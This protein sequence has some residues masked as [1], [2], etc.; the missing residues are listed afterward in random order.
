M[1]HVFSLFFIL[2]LFGT[3]LY[4]ADLLPQSI[5]EVKTPG[6]SEIQVAG[7]SYVKASSVFEY[8]YGL[9]RAG[10]IDGLR[11]NLML[12]LDSNVVGF[13]I[14]IYTE[15][16]NYGFVYNLTNPKG[17]EVI[18]PSPIGVPK[19]LLDRPDV[20]G[21]GQMLSQNAMMLEVYKENSV[22]PVPNSDKVQIE[23]GRWKFSIAVE[24][25][26]PEIKDS[27][28]VSVFVKK[29]KPIGAKTRGMIH[30]QTFA[31]IESKVPQNLQQ[32]KTFIEHPL[33]LENMGIGIQLHQ[34]TALNE[35]FDTMCDD[36][37]R[38]CY[39][40]LSDLRRTTVARTPGVLNIHFVKRNNFSNAGIAN[41]GGSV[42]SLFSNTKDMFDGVFVWTDPSLQ[43]ALENTKLTFVHELG[44]HL[45]LYHT[46]QDCISDTK[47][48]NH[49]IEGNQNPI[50]TNVMNAGITGSKGSF[51]AG[52]RDILLRSTVVELYEP[53]K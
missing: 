9:V 20:L 14:V 6:L 17:T 43:S 28:R 42:S 48:F 52:Q 7:K 39:Q 31:S 53:K 4:A 10:L 30:V 26:T 34:H 40:M 35:K 15:K 25:L 12:D 46:N 21:R 32:M 44:H 23:A 29:S 47:D 18:S 1:P 11:D 45:G 5:K 50:G 49:W 3:G 22:S 36:E 24:E 37:T 2:T 33:V 41:L 19:N 13:S 27:F 16:K 51:S 38:P 8:S